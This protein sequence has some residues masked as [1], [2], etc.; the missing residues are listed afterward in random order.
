L[1]FIKL[2]PPEGRDFLPI[3][4]IVGRLRDEFAVVDVDKDGGWDHVASM[5]AATL[6]FSDELPH[7][8]GQLTKLQSIQDEAVY[9]SFGDCLSTAA[10][11]CLI[12]ASELFFDDPDVLADP[13]RSLLVRCAAALEYEMYGG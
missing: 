5:I 1:A 7:K 3:D 8:Q 11:C 9:V 4:E 6:E 10:S 12:P 2:F 13:G